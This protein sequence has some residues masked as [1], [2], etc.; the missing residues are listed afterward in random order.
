MAAIRL[1]M[2]D[3]IVFQV[4]RKD[5]AAESKWE[6]VDVYPL[7]VKPATA[8]YTY[9]SRTKM[10]QTTHKSAFIDRFGL[11]PIP[12]TLAGSFGIQ[13]R[14]A[15][16]NFK[17]GYTRLLEF[18]DEVVKLTNSVD[19]A[20]VVNGAYPSISLS[21]KANAK[22]VYAVNF[23]DFI[24][25]E[26]YAINID[27]FNINVS[28]TYNPFEPRYSLSFTAF[29]PPI[30]TNAPTKDA[31]LM[32]LMQVSAIVTSIEDQANAL[33][34]VISGNAV[35]Q[36]VASVA[37]LAGQMVDLVGRIGTLGALYMNAIS[38]SVMGFVTSQRALEKQQNVVVSTLMD[39]VK[40]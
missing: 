15:G 24:Y 1:Q 25:N 40:G 10:V 23:Y 22:Y 34:D 5:L 37:I 8:D 18:R 35:I 30:A 33:S 7:A 38:G 31:L 36:N 28:A 14:A 11:Q 39:V 27:S 29:G 13:P 4:I 9:A 32:A 16:I 19:N 2:A 6:E 20:L 3:A 21:A 26:M 12:I 17:D